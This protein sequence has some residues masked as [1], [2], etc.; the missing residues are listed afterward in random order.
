MSYHSKA[1][2]REEMNLKGFFK[3][4]GIG[5]GKTYFFTV[6]FVENVIDKKDAVHAWNILRTQITKKYKLFRYICIWERQKRG[7]WH[8]H[9]ICNCPSV[10]ALYK[11]IDYVKEAIW[12]SNTQLGFTSAIWT[13][14]NA[15]SCGNYMY[16]Y[17]NK[18]TREKGIRYINYSRNFVRVCSSQFMFVG[19]LAGVW[20]GC[21]RVLNDMFP[22]TF[23]FFYENARFDYLLSCVNGVSGDAKSF[24]NG[25]QNMALYFDKVHYL[26]YKERFFIQLEKYMND[27][28]STYKKIYC[29]V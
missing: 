1:L 8:C 4:Y 9:V 24:F 18:E 10:G 28:K 26:N 21:C 27:C 20:R 7:A 12:K 2:Y 5:R 19:G 6:T 16:K 13:H 3:K 25:L 29:E 11:F 15:V 17:L 22:D 23:K 14:G